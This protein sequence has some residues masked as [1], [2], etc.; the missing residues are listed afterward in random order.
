MTTYEGA[1]RGTYAFVLDDT[2]FRYLSIKRG[3]SGVLCGSVHVFTTQSYLL[4]DS[5]QREHKGA[6]GRLICLQVFE[7]GEK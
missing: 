3:V 4:S 6:V 2:T 1:D 5:R 7:A